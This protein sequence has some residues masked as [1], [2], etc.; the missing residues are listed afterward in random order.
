MRKAFTVVILSCLLF[1]SAGLALDVARCANPSGKGY[2]PF[3]GL[4]GKNDAGW[5]DEKI[6]GGLAT[7]TRLSQ[8]EYDILFTDATKSVVSSKQDG[9]KVLRLFKGSNDAMFLVVYP[10]GTV[11]T[12]TFLI[13]KAGKS[14]YMV[15]TSRAGN[16]GFL[17]KSTVM[18]GDCQ[19]VN[20]DMVD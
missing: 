20:L 3:L 5:Q 12:Y 9:G 4:V 2:Y 13:N 17:A 6:S 10:Q 11:E 19:F 14:E 18:R 8:G 15:T 1:P 16:A 7:L